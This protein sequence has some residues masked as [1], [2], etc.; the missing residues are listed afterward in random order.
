MINKSS[1]EFSNCMVNALLAEVITWPTPGLVSLLDNGIHQDM[2]VFTFVRS[3]VCL[4]PFFQKA[5]QQGKLAM[6][7]QLT[8]IQLSLA[9]QQLGIKAESAM[10]QETIKT[11]THKGAIFLGIL[12]SAA[13]GMH[14]HLKSVTLQQICQTAGIIG[15]PLIIK[16]FVET[17]KN[18]IKLTPGLNAYLTYGIKGIRGEVLSNFASIITIGIPS[19]QNNLE[20]E[21]C[22]RKATAQL[23]LQFMAN[24]EDTTVLNRKF[25]IRRIHYVKRTAKSVLNAGGIYSNRGKVLLSKLCHLYKKRSISPGGSADLV[26]MTLCLYFWEYGYPQTF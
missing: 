19:L 20:K 14:S 4:R 7:K 8:M 21:P 26:A 11:N 17:K 9:L 22:L 2:N 13:V 23:L 6:T 25:D 18:S 1:K 10:Y 24:I 16:H 3:A 5:V 15:K 12:L